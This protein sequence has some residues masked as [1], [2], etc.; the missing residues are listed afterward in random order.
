MRRTFEVSRYIVLS[1][2]S[3]FALQFPTTAFGADGSKVYLESD[4]L[5]VLGAN[6]KMAT[7]EGN[8]NSNQ[9][10]VEEDSGYIAFDRVTVIEKRDN[11]VTESY[12]QVRNCRMLKSGRAINAPAT[13]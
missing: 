13:E 10:F 11:A 7:V 4:C 2:V 12:V 8:T 1:L 5:S 3:V 9:T 6:R